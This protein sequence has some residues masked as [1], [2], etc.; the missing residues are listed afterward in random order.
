V[1][2][3][4][5]FSEFMDSENA[6]VDI[7]FARFCDPVIKRNDI[8]FDVENMIIGGRFYKKVK[9]TYLS[10]RNAQV[11]YSEYND[12][13]TGAGF[14][15]ER[16]CYLE[17]ANAPIEENV[18][19]LN[20]VVTRYG[21]NFAYMGAK[22]EAEFCEIEPYEVGEPVDWDKLIGRTRKKIMY[23]W[24]T[25]QGGSISLDT[26]KIP[27]PLIQLIPLA[28]KWGTENEVIGIKVVENA[29]LEDLETLIEMMKKFNDQV[30]NNWLESPDSNK[31]THEPEYIIFSRLRDAYDNATIVYEKRKNQQK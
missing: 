6:E 4:K 9:L 2:K 16:Y 17:I 26:S 21:L 25:E 20:G 5:N 22:I 11:D 7:E 3:Y 12:T 28:I 14:K 27:I 13:V 10:V 18:F 30:L 23:K 8:V 29:S 1:F 24:T 19:F 15:G 31:M